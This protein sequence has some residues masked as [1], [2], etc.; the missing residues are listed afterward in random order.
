MHALQ[1]KLNIL[2]KYTRLYQ[3]LLQIMAEAGYI[4]LE[5]GK[6]TCL[7]ANKIEE[8]ELQHEKA[9]LLAKIPAL[10]AHIELLWSCLMAYPAILTGARSHMQ[11]MFPEGSLSLVEG[12]YQNN[13]TAD[14]YNERVAACVKAYV[15]ERIKHD[16][17]AEIVILEVGAGTG[18]TSRFVLQAL[19]P[20][21]APLRYFYTDV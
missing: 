5:E 17:Q 13:P 8:S 10:K 11:V 19:A 21:K 1:K 15:K 14:Y 18:G 12:I 7:I 9:A 20:L 4:T 2:E 3:V 16:P 6:V